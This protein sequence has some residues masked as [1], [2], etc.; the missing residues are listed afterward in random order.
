MFVWCGAVINMKSKWYMIDHWCRSRCLWQAARQR[1]QWRE[2]T[3]GMRHMAAKTYDGLVK[4]SKGRRSPFGSSRTVQLIVLGGKLVSAVMAVVLFG[5]GW[6][7][8][9]MRFECYFTKPSSKPA[10]LSG[11]QRD[12]RQKPV[13]AGK[14]WT[15]Q[16]LAGHVSWSPSMHHAPRFLFYT[17]LGKRMDWWLW[18]VPVLNNNWSH[19]NGFHR[20]RPTHCIERMVTSSKRCECMLKMNC[21]RNLIWLIF[22]I[23]SN[24]L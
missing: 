11:F 3:V 12:R 24:V 20:R 18:I 23:F 15:G 8:L 19:I 14:I 10:V 17:C 9:N 2:G 22:N 5:F 4:G 21:C 13:V 6:N 1:L 7:R 16:S